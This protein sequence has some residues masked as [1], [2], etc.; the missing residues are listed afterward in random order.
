MGGRGA[1]ILGL[2]VW[3]ALLVAP[4]M[5]ASGLAA[6]LTVAAAAA[7]LALRAPPRTASAFALIAV[8]AAALA[9]GGA[10]SALA[11]RQAAHVAV[12][13]PI[14]RLVV[15][16]EE[17]PRR[18]GGEPVATTRVIAATPPMAEGTRL[19]LRWKAGEPGEWADT[20]EVLARIDA[21]SGPRLPGGFDARAALRAQGISAHAHALAVQRRAAAGMA[22]VPLAL[23]TR[24]RRACER[25]LTRGLGAEA[26][27]L[28]APLLFGDR[29]AMTTEVDAS[30]RASGLVHLLALS[31][32]HVAW[33][34]A[35]ARGAAAMCGA[36]ARRRALAGAACAVG[37]A[38]LAGPIPSL[39]RASA[40]ELVV[41]LAQR[42]ERAVDPVQALAVSAVALLWLAP[43]WAGDLGFQLSCAATL[44]LVV[45]GGPL[46]AWLH[47]RVPARLPAALVTPL[48]ATFAAQAMALPLLIARFHAV[49]WTGLVA[50][51]LAVPV[52]ELLLAGAWLGALADAS[53]PGAGGVWF[54]ACVPLASALRA[55]SRAAAEVPW[56]LWACGE[57]SWAAWAAAVGVAAL[58]CAAAAP[59][60]ALQTRRARWRDGMQGA[61]LTALALALLAVASERESRPP[62]A[63][64]WLVVLDVGQGDAIALATPEGWWLID[65][66]ARSPQWD[67]GEG[68]VLPFFRWAGVRHL[69]R[70]VLT[71]DDS[72]HTGGV[73]ATRR[74]VR[75]R[76]EVA[77]ASLPGVPGPEAGR[78]AFRA[79]RGDTLR[80]SDPTVRVLWPPRAGEPDAWIAGRGDNA[81]SLVLRVGEGSA[82]ALLL[83]DVDS[84]SEAALLLEPA[85][86]LKA[87]HHGSGSS[88]SHATIARAAPSIAVLSCGRRNRH[89]HPEPRL[90][91]R[92]A[93]AGVAADRTDRAGT[94]VYAFERGALRRVDWRGGEWRSAAMMA[95]AAGAVTAA[96]AR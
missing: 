16:L 21:P 95:A 46:A 17:P 42:T 10:A 30:L 65:T 31:G 59:R 57:G 78:A 87:G 37:Y 77:P 24:L 11:D 54:S 73:A 96:R 25:A 45:L 60:A 49:P 93:A 43:G 74:G 56:A 36:N 92:L 26:H 27:E 40:T 88:T 85:T 13:V 53:L 86:L 61:G 55:V 47:E 19:R 72:D 66:G 84:V 63:S 51:L 89:G 12:S 22:V 52:A 15:V 23:A 64:W 33:M 6:W 28:A 20:L 39:W 69:Q 71:H 67:A 94:L 48:A 2:V 9:R 83:A 7:L 1:V 75:V 34:A 41:A 91:Q 81:A 44:G 80:A 35:V 32:L 82:A 8:A 4:S 58:A 62:H 79:A 3:A 18:E 68:V 29:S 70:L 38:L 50:N 5:R 76:R 14:A 90:L